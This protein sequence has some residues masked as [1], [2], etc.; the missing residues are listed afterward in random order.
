M[1]HSLTSRVVEKDLN[2]AAGWYIVLSSRK[3]TQKPVAVRLFGQ[4]LVAWRNSSG[5]PVLMEEHC[6]HM[7]ASLV[8]GRVVNDCIECPFHKW[9]F[10]GG[11]GKCASIPDTTHIP[12][13]AY[14]FVYTNLIERYGYLWAWYGTPEPLFALP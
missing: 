8:G 3:L 6:S 14:Q 11:S 10:N 7:G 4:D 2:L 1:F 12:Q 13:T 9:Q 5:K